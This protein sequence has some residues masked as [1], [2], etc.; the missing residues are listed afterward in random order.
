M[1]SKCQANGRRV[2]R[3]DSIGARQCKTK[4]IVAL[5]TSRCETMARETMARETMARE[6]TAREMTAREMMARYTAVRVFETLRFSM[7]AR[8]SIPAG[9]IMELSW[10]PIPWAAAKQMIMDMPDGL[11][12][13]ATAVHNDSVTRLMNIEKSGNFLNYDLQM[14]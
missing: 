9:F 7:K 14:P 8:V 3:Q 4:E 11:S 2:N 13:I 10:W 12:T 5:A 1:D 6:M